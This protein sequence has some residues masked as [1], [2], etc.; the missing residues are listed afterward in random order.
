M[1]GELQPRPE[2]QSALEAVT[3]N[4]DPM[5]LAGI[6]DRR[7]YNPCDIFPFLALSISKSGIPLQSMPLFRID[8]GD[9]SPDSRYPFP[10]IRREDERTDYGELA[11]LGL[12]RIVPSRIMSRNKDV[13]IWL[14]RSI[15]P[16][17]LHPP[18][19][20]AAVTYITSLGIDWSPDSLRETAINAN[21]QTLRAPVPRQKMLLELGG[22]PHAVTASAVI[23]AVMRLVTAETHAT[24]DGKRILDG[25][26]KRHPNAKLIQSGD[27]T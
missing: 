27:D 15:E 16:L 6:W 12:V 21:F 3:R 9:T 13:Q 10:I 17:K 26:L 4:Y 5:R 22:P 19:V 2:P 8:A 23:A 1:T 20:E 7:P 25:F 11:E 14:N 24:S 18:I